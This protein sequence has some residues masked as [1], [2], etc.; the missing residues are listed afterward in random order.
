MSWTYCS[1]EINQ[2][3]YENH[4]K[5]TVYFLKKRSAYDGHSASCR[6]TTKSSNKPAA[7]EDFLKLRA[8]I[9]ELNQEA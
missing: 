9:D 3:R 1:H 6:I 8:K 7:F 4:K 2:T 5:N